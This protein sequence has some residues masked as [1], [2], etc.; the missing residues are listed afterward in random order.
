MGW[1]ITLVQKVLGAIAVFLALGSITGTWQHLST[2]WQVFED[3]DVAEASLMSHE[4]RFTEI[5]QTAEDI[6]KGQKQIMDQ[7]GNL[8]VAVL[9]P[10][11]TGRATICDCG[12]DE[13]F[14]SINSRGDAQSYLRQEKARITCTRDGIE[15]SVVL[16]IRGRFTNNDSGHLIMFSAKAARD[17][18]LQGIIRSVTV[19]SADKE[20]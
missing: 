5:E 11:V 3:V 13:A 4:T 12:Y 14:I 10:T 7:I 2:S 1:E 19:S 18:G 17:L 8:A 20:E 6:M 15:H 9:T 16:D